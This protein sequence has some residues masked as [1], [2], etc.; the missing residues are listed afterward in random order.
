MAHFRFQLGLHVSLRDEEFVL[1]SQ[2]NDSLWIL[3][4]VGN[5]TQFSCTTEEPLRK[6]ENH[7]LIALLDNIGRYPINKRLEQ[8]LHRDLNTFP[9]HLIAIAKTILPYMQAIDEQQTPLDPKHLTEM[10]TGVSDG[11]EGKAPSASRVYRLYRDWIASGRDIRALIPS[12]SSRGRKRLTSDETLA[13]IVQN[14]IHEIYL[15]R[16]P[17]SVAD[18]QSHAL[19]SVEDQNTKGPPSGRI[20]LP[21]LSTF[22]REIDRTSKF[23]VAKAQKGA[24]QAR[25]DYRMTIKGPDYSRPL[26]V[27]EVDETPSDLMFLDDQTFLPLGRGTVTVIVDDF[28]TALL[29]LRTEFAPASSSTIARALRQAILPKTLYRD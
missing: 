2:T 3:K 13:S 15:Q 20:T 23:E 10:I 26:E 24:R 18:V 7:E 25:I 9:P 16:V 4:N 19:L 1:D 28:T 27:C 14:S 11:K 5:G 12:Y 17:G 6:Y 22:Y 21:S 29:S 8:K